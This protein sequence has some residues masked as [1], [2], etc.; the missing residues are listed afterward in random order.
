M[1]SLA[2][3]CKLIMELYLQ[4][5]KLGVVN[6]MEKCACINLVVTDWFE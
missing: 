1:M 3:T 2:Q 5:L 4:L 6:L